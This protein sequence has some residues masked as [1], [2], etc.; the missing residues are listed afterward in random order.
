MDRLKTSPSSVDDD[1]FT[2]VRSGGPAGDRAVMRLY[3]LYHKDITSCMRLFLIRH[4]QW[5]G[6]A[7]DIT[8][9]S[10]IVMIDKI[11]CDN[12]CITTAR[13]FWLGI[14]K[15][16]WLNQNKRNKLMC[17]ANDEDH[18]YG[19]SEITPESIL[20]NKERFRR[21]EIYLSHFNPKYRT[22]MLMWLSDYSMQ[23]IAEQLHLSGA[24]VARKIKFMC[25]KRMKA[26]LHKN[27]I[28]KP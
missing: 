20:I 13:S 5:Y 14:A 21:I 24:H 23:E 1:L 12:P 2:A 7:E 27:N 15:Y 18:F 6:E 9:D 25:C 19:T 3:S 11:R 4:G 16:M 26:M 22:L 10:F 8:H 28:L 17:M